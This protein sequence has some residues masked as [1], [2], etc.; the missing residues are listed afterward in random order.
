MKVEEVEAGSGG[1]HENQVQVPWVE[2]YYWQ[3]RIYVKAKCDHGHTKI[4]Q[5]F[6]E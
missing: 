2:L 1:E 4:F 3:G 6:L 5:F